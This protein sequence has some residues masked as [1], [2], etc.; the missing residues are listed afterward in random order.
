[1][2]TF[3]KRRPIYTLP[4]GI[5]VI[6]EYAPS[7]KNPYWRVRIRPHPFFSGLKVVSDGVNTTRNRV[8]MASLLG[9]DIARNEH[10]HHK[11]ED[12]TDDRP[13]NLELLL[14]ADHNRHHKLGSKHS[15]DTKKKISAGLTAAIAEGRREP[16]PRV[17]S[18]G[19]THSVESKMKM[20]ATKKRLIREGVIEKQTPPLKRGEDSGVAKFCERQVREIRRRAAKGEPKAVLAGEFGVHKNSIYNIVNRKTWEHIA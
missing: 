15:A 7:G 16:P 14:S 18:N 11:N 3:A 13:E 4:H 10:V 19:K 8:V 5:E 12:R 9:R 20:S 2:A 6:G 17:D 1:M